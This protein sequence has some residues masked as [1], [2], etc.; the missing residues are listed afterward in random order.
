MCCSP[1]VWQSRE[2]QDDFSLCFYFCFSNVYRPGVNLFFTLAGW[3]SF[4]QTFLSVSPDALCLQKIACYCSAFPKSNLE[5]KRQTQLSSQTCF[6]APPPSVSASIATWFCKKKKTPQNNKHRRNQNASQKY[7]P[8]PK[9]VC[10]NKFCVSHVV[11]RSIPIVHWFW[12]FFCGI[13]LA[14][15]IPA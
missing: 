13:V 3:F 4:L 9:S 2:W 11:H 12:L 8:F 1:S 10:T 7:N 5:K 14:S 15:V 6:K